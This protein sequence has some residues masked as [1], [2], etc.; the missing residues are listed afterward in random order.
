MNLDREV[1]QI[2]KLESEGPYFQGDAEL[3]PSPRNVTFVEKMEQAK[4]H[5]RHPNRQGVSEVLMG[6]VIE[7]VDILEDFQTKLLN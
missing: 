6:G 2:V 7:V 4:K 5:W 1:L 3:L